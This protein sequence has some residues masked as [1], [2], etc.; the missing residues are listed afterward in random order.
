MSEPVLIIPFKLR[1]TG[2]DA[3]KHRVASYVGT[4]SIYGFTRSMQIATQAYLNQ[5]AVSKATALHDADL[6]LTGA[7]PGSLTFDFRLEVLKK[8]VGVPQNPNAFFDF[9]STV[10]MRATGRG[11]SPT[12]PYVA[13]I[14]RDPESDL[15]DLTIEQIEESLKEAHSAIGGSVEKIDFERPRTGS[16]VFF[17]QE[18]KSYI[19]SSV[20]ADSDRRYKGHVT[21][22]NS[23]TG[24]GR[25]YIISLGRVVPFKLQEE[26]LDGKRGLLTWSLHGSNVHRAKNLNFDAMEITSSAGT[27]K[28]LA[29]NDCNP[30][31]DD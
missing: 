10:F 14:D 25:A 19:Q 17:D 11:Y 4:K 26:F 1:L 22:F 16:Q 3:E 9:C 13:K 5:E 21:R 8:K 24:N 15:I 30:V 31:G 6:F 20:M 12:T 2:K 27:V 7:K 29:L 28:R 23:I 18:T